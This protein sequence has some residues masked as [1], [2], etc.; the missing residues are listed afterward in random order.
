MRLCCC[1]FVLS[2]GQKV[3]LHYLDCD[4]DVTLEARRNHNEVSDF[5]AHLL[6]RPSAVFILCQS[7]LSL[8]C[9]AQFLPGV[10][11]F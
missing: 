4:E 3:R 6:A 8:D 2:Y 5:H 7:S 9:A 10:L 11:F 1:R